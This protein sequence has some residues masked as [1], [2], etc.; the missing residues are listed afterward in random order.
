ML[1]KIVFFTLV[2]SI[3]RTQAIYKLKLTLEQITKKITN[4]QAKMPKILDKFE[5]FPNQN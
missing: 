1:N 2:A 4:G 3:A 5:V